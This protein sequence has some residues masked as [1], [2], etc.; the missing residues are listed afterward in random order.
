MDVSEIMF[1]LFGGAREVSLLQSAHI[2]FGAHP[3]V[4]VSGMGAFWSY[5]EA[6]DT[7]HSA[8]VT[9]ERY[10]FFIY[11]V[12]GQSSFTVFTSHSTLCN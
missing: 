2:A 11:L 4:T 7:P 9:E 3:A 10:C 5:R 12:H 1:R 8:G 6:D